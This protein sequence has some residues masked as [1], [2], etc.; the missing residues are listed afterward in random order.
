MTS[1]NTLR[2]T[3][4]HAWLKAFHREEELK[5]IDAINESDFWALKD[6]SFAMNSGEILGVIGNNG[7]GKSTLLKILS[8]IT[9]PTGGEAVIRG[10]VSSLLEVGT[11]FHPDLTGRENVFLNGAIIGMGRKEIIRQFDAIASFAEIGR[12]IDTPVKRYSS[13]MYVRLAFAIAAHLDPDVLMIDEVLAVGDASF[14]KK[15]LQKSHDVAHSGKTVII[16]SH[17]LGVIQQLCH[18]AIHLDQG[19]VI[20]DGP[21]KD[22][23]ASYQTRCAA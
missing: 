21:A 1:P 12:F 4:Q 10:R 18:R 17:D 8:R 19:R 2:E 22:V 9:E 20:A 15:C 16:V 3:F 13:G 7:S 23:L 6:V 14:Q 11:G 5:K